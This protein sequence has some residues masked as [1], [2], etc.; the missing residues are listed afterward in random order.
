MPAEIEK[1]FCR[2]KGAIGKFVL[3]AFLLGSAF[4]LS[5]WKLADFA[6]HDELFSYILLIPLTC[7]YLAWLQGKK[8]PLVSLPDK[9]WAAIFFT[10]GIVALAAHFLK[11]L[12]AV[13]DSLVLPTLAFIL[14][15]TGAGFLTLGKTAMR[16]LAFPFALLIFMVPL[17]DVLRHGLETWLQYGSAFFAS[18]MFALSG[19]TVFQDGLSFQLPTITL[20]IAPECSGIHSSVVLFIVSL[21]SA[22]FFLHQSW[23]RAVLC[24]AV[25]PL[26]LLR[27]G[28]R[29]FVLGEL[30]THIGPQMIDSPIHH[31]GGPLFFA[32]SLIPFSLLLYF[33]IKSE[34]PKISDI[35]PTANH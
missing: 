31:R 9:K 27:N 26:V 6:A 29:V 25:I 13:A 4:S 24:L 1:K 11:P 34:R 15:L 32:L 20:Q 18:W 22:H 8:L 30:C 17:P 5:L 14:F 28:F 19:T 10:G 16:V 7:L 21:V 23:K 2:Q 12:S 33:L 3:A 35:P